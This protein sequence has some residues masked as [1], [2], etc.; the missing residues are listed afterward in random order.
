MRS[1]AKLTWE[2]RRVESQGLGFLH[3]LGHVTSPG[4]SWGC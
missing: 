3:Q 4:K 2:T 1:A